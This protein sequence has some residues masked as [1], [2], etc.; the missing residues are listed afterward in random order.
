MDTRLLSARLYSGSRSPGGG[1]YLYT[2]PIEPAQAASLVA[3]FNGGFIV[4]VAGGGY[5][6]GDRM[7]DPLRPGRPPWWSTPAEASTSAPGAATWS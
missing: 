1:P 7:V 2:A 4:N 5:Y 6:T 3:A